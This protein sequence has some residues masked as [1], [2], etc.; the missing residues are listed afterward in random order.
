MLAS[1]SYDNTAKVF[2]FKTGKVIKV[3]YSEDGSNLASYKAPFI[4]NI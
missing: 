3:G 1:T 4:T 2:D